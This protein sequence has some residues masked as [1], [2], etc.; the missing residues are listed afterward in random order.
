MPDI[1]KA[2]IQIEPTT[3]GLSAAIAKE[4]EPAG[5]SAGDSVGK[6]LAGK[7]KGA[8]AAAGIGTAIVKTIKASLDAGGAL[9]QS[10]GGL[11]TLYGDAADQ[12]K[13]FAMQAAQ[14]GISANDYAEQAVSFGASLKAAF[15]G[16]T[17]KAAEA[18]NTAIMDMADNS[19]KMGSDI[20][21]VQAAY[22]GFS[23]QNYT[24]LDNLKLGYGGTKTEMERLL[25]DAEKLS[26]VKYDI[27]NLGDVYQAI[28]VIQE[29]LGLTGVA[30]QEAS[31][32]LT[33][34][35]GAAKASLTN[36]LAALSTGG[37]VAGTLQ[38]LLTS[39]STLLFNNVVPMVW[40]IVQAIPPAVTAALQ[41]IAPMIGEGFQ[42]AIGSLPQLLNTGVMLV[43]NLVTGVLQGMPGF[44]SSAFTMLTQFVTGIMRNLP[45][46]LQAGVQ[47][48]LN[49]VTG[50]I[51]NLPQIVGAAGMGIAQ[52]VA[53]IGKVLPQVLQSGVQILAQLVVGIINSIPR[54]V[55][56]VPQCI[57]A[58]KSGFQGHNWAEIGTNIINGLVNGIK[59][60][61]GKIAD[62]A[63]N[64]AKS[65]LDAAKSFLGIKSPS[66]VFEK[67]VGYW[68]PAGVAKGIN[69]NSSIVTDAL[70]N[71][72]GNSVYAFSAEMA[73]SRF[74]TSTGMAGGFN[75]TL[76]IYSPRELT[77]SE[78]ARQTRNATQQ[79]VLSMGV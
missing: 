63:K 67:E 65:A 1:G 29:D 59:S 2:F 24:M 70:D 23:K 66:K 37:D 17:V 69:K 11:E 52:F 76:N 10:F 55:A 62:A 9:Q 44:I 35:F 5:A 57:S 7:I 12:A 60:G 75:Q 53:G 16:D 40:N 46:I 68:I 61:V 8:L 48:V 20:T 64:A 34:A 58:F 38:Q 73:A 26:G 18:A 39:V 19:S 27:N 49:L 25:K 14:A 41:A 30:A 71:L 56:A 78:V 6:G 13:E 72:T 79:I 28:H 74:D 22:A 15:G 36:F 21:A 32:T 42:T 54:L 33:G 3:K 77:P 31:T 51:N 43:N 45:N 50:I 47:I 4:L